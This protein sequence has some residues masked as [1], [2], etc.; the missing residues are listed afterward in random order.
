VPKLLDAS[1]DL[2]NG[3]W[4]MN[5][6]ST[7]GIKLLDHHD[8]IEMDTVVLWQQDVLQ[9][10][11]DAEDVT[12][13]EWLLQLLR[14]SSEQALIAR[15]DKKHDKL[16]V[17]Q[18]G[19]ITY[20]K[21][22]LDEMFTMSPGIVSSLQ[23]ELK[24]FGREGLAQF[25]D[26][27]VGLCVIE[28]DAIIDRLAE[29]DDLPRDTPLWILKGLCKCDVE[30]F[31]KP[32]NLLLATAQLAQAQNKKSDLSATETLQLAKE[33]TALATDLF[34]TLNI[35]KEFNIPGGGG[36]VSICYNCE[37]NDGHI[38][39]QC[40][41]PR[42]EAKVKRNREAAAAARRNSGGGR[43]G[44]GRGG[45]GAGR[46]GAGRGRGRG[47]GNR[48][49]WGEDPNKNGSRETNGVE[50]RGNHWMMWCKKGC[51]WNHTHTS[52]YHSAFKRE[53][54]SFC[55]PRE[56]DFW[57]MS[58]KTPPA[59]SNGGGGGGGQSANAGGGAASSNANDSQLRSALSGIVDRH[60][61][62]TE[63]ADIASL[64]ADLKQAL[65]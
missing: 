46:G 34:N 32:F 29:V 60:M 24:K 28:L 3:R 14:N 21:L 48:K 36:R 52:G 65:N 13:T 40:P 41:E 17:L 8:K 53:G 62:V 59:A 30:E 44:A 7:T 58:G 2:D 51:D 31:V 47:R 12:S 19:G 33:H 1:V 43:G 20:L 63:N 42:D 25:P 9:W 27:N 23:D 37:K 22:A 6:I 15:L 38:A 39:P 26:Q 50:K 54:A 16:P 55:L 11:N 5:N 56:H 10:A 45:G 4:D 18:Q 35:S 61:S 64:C 49:K 57:K